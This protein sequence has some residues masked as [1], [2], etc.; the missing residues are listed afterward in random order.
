ML[1]FKKKDDLRGFLG[2]KTNKGRKV[3]FV[4]TMGALHEGHISLVERSRQ[5]NSITVCS[6]FVNP[7]QFNDPKDFEKYPVTIEQ[8]LQRLEQSGCD[9]LFLPSGDEIYPHGLPTTETY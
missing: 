5:D 7:T 9:L 8:D 1:L 3:G 6:I 2:Q 4:P